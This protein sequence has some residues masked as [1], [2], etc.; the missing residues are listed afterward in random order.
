MDRVRAR[1]PQ[2]AATGLLT[3]SVLAGLLFGLTPSAIATAEAGGRYIVSFTES[4]TTDEVAAARDHAIAAGAQIIYDYD[5]A[6]SGFAALLPDAA[7]ADLQ[8]D[9]LVAEVEPDEVMTIAEETSTSSTQSGVTNGLDRIDQ[10]SRKLNGKFT[11]STAGA[12]VVAYVIDTG[13]MVGHSEFGGRVEAGRSFTSLPATTDCGEGHGTHVAGLI[14][15]ET[16]GVAKDVTIVPVKVFSCGGSASVSTVIAGIEWATENHQQRGG[17]AVINLSAG[18]GKNLGAGLEQAAANAIKAG[19]SFVTAAGNEGGSACAHSPARLG[20]AITVGAVSSSDKR[21]GFSNFG[22]CVDLFAPGL[23]VVSAGIDS[24][25]DTAMKDGTSMAAPYVSGVVAAFL[26]RVPSANPAKVRSALFK[27]TTRGRLRNIGSSPNRMLYSVLKVANKAPRVGDV[28]VALPGKDRAVGT[29]TVPVR[30]SW[31]GSDPDGTVASYQLQRS[32]DGGRHWNSVALPAAAARSI[33]LNLGADS[34]HRFRVRAIDNLGRP[35]AWSTSDKLGLT[36]D[37]QGSAK[38]RRTWSKDT[39]SDL[40]GGSSHGTRIKGASATYTFT[41]RTVRWIGTTDLDHGKARVYLDGR[42]VATVDAYSATRQTCQVLFATT[43][44]PG[45]HTLR[46][47]V[48]GQNS[49]RSSGD[50]VDIDAF[51]VTS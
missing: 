23:N 40:A 3:G 4:A 38:L 50:R 37:Q 28:K 14:G 43:T 39:G 12:G 51:V 2:V 15:G 49:N 5:T 48:M 6:L 22:T 20:P 42:L 36:V 30:I 17:P 9:P 31:T 19:I 41:G 34:G 16:Y 44:G 11:Y 32:T 29:S 24:P 27:A 13:V 45:R 33:T 47:V 21:A 25:T 35:G 1:A 26:Q 8:T 10:R 7:R 18:V 46:I